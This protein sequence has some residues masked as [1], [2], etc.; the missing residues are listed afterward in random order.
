MYGN[1]YD[2]TLNALVAV[3]GKLRKFRVR[4]TLTFYRLRKNVIPGAGARKLRYRWSG[5]RAYTHCKLS[6]AQIGTGIRDELVD[7]AQLHFP[8]DAE[9]VRL[10]G[11]GTALKFTRDMSGLQPLTVQTINLEF[12]GAERFGG[13]ASSIV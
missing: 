5:K 12:T 11:F 2:C 7:A 4:A 3:V 1:E 8:A 13:M 6:G 10:D 9:A